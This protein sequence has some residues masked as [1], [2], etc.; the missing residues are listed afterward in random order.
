MSA[1]RD[2]MVIIRATFNES[3]PD[4]WTIGWESVLEHPIQRAV[5]L[6]VERTRM[7]EVDAFLSRR[8][9]V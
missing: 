3:H 8:P 1:L 4:V 6:Q 2:A 7:G 5:S 9:D